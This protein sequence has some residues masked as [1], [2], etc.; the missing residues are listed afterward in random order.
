MANRAELYNDHT[1]SKKDILLL[2]GIDNFTR[3]DLDQLRLRREAGMPEAILSICVS[4]T[5]AF[6]IRCWY[7]YALSNKKPNPAQLSRVEYE[8]LID[9]AVELGAKTMIVCGDGEPTYDPHLTNIISHAHQHGLTPVVVTNGTVFGNDAVAMNKHGMSGRQLAQF[10]YDHGA[11]L[12]V[13]LETLDAD[14]YEDIVKI[15]GAWN[16]FSTGISRLTEIGFGGTWDAEDGTYTRLSFTGIATTENINEVP[17]L[18]EWAR[19]KGAQ[20]ICKVPSPTGGALDSVQKLFPPDKVGE[21]R[22][23]IDHYTDKRETLTPVV[24]DGDKCMTCLAWHLGPVITETG[25]YVECYTATEFTFGNVRE[26]SLRQIL[27]DKKK[28]TDFDNPCPIKDRLYAKL[29]ASQA[30]AL[31]LA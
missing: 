19:S 10:L 30:V 11:S 14:L 1:F 31:P 23:Q 4:T 13:K 16:W 26:K 8:E 21:V 22:K 27:L 28:G 15:P 20:Y 7:C 9:Q 29:T 25:D 6:N 18:R 3:S 2:H 17:K 5:A 12:L 24:L